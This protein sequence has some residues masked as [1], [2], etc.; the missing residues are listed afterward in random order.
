MVRARRDVGE[1]NISAGGD[2]IVVDGRPTTRRAL[3][4]AAQTLNV[5]DRKVIK[6]LKSQRQDWQDEAWDCY[7]TTPL[8]G[9]SSDFTA[10]ALSRLRF[11]IAWQANVSDDPSEVNIDSPPEEMP[12]DAYVKAQAILARL[13]HGQGLMEMARKAAYGLTIPG[14]LYVLGRDEEDPASGDITERFDAYSTSEL[15]LSKADQGKIA[16]QTEP[17][18]DGE[19]IE[20]DVETAVFFRVW[21]PHP[22][23][24]QI[25][26]TPMRR[27]LEQCEEQALLRRYMRSASRSR[28]NMGLLEVPEEWELGPVHNKREGETFGYDRMGDE[29]VTAFS[30]GIADEAS[31]QNVVPY[32]VHAKAA[33][34]GKARLI[35]FGRDFDQL[36]LEM[37]R[38]LD[39]EIAS[40]IDLPD[41]V[42][43][44]LGDVKF[45][46]AEV[47]TQEQ[48]KLHL[49][50][51]AIVWVR[52]LT[53]GF[54]TVMLEDEGVAP[55]I[56]RQFTIWYDSAAVTSQTDQTASSN[57]GYDRELISGRT[58]RQVNNYTEEDA[59]DEEERE[60]RKA[61]APEA[62]P[63]VPPQQGF[64]P[65]P[66]DDEGGDTAKPNPFAPKDAGA[67]IVASGRRQR[68]AVQQLGRRLAV[69]ELATRLKVQTA[70]DQAMRRAFER[71]GSASR[72]RAGKVASATLLKGV[73]NR[74]IV[75]TI[76]LEAVV[77][78][79]VNPAAHL[80]AEL[81]RLHD[82][83]VE[84]VQ[85]HQF[86]VVEMIAKATRRPAGPLIERSAASWAAGV[87]NAWAEMYGR[88]HKL[89]GDEF[90][91]SM[92]AA[93][94]RKRPVTPAAPEGE[95]AEFL[96]EF[97]VTMS[98]PAGLV[99][100]MLSIAGGVT[101]P[102]EDD[103]ETMGGIIGGPVMD[104][105]FDA[106]GL[107]D[108][109]SD[110]G[111]F[112]W[113][114]GDSSTRIRPFEPHERLNGE[115]FTDYADPIL[116]NDEA[117]PDG[118]YYFPG[119]HAYC[120]CEVAPRLVETI[121][122]VVDPVAPSTLRA[123]GLE[124]APAAEAEAAKLGHPSYPGNPPI[125]VFVGQEE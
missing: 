2:T 74:D 27:V 93:A 21:R 35:T 49:E 108:D 82:T 92:V 71:I 61:A 89:A 114:Y 111:G 97:D 84:I 85:A 39:E 112:E 10:N 19:R 50:P 31:A 53:V 20:I 9:F 77:R 36:A 118:P 28:L 113:L 123:R 42:L 65:A 124:K 11:L 23:F 24:S 76:G 67:A 104:D 87:E 15:D 102:Q 101:V 57:F 73:E 17:G 115:F 26:S 44:G 22:R 122:A 12:L 55:E 121:P 117:F 96:G 56:A 7:D 70:A 95:A 34:L 60:Q 103:P 94:P 14:E 69:T 1:T 107:S 64:S 78:L 110:G 33:T 8:V 6:R 52:A 38:R 75:A 45:R 5:A 66:G 32:I 46:N 30:T 62:L 68:P 58:W 109:P 116:T 99:R 16:I 106:V 80:D 29:L 4:A 79:G 47:I 86:R 3:T 63:V 91:L 119:D 90:F 51:L 88:L 59:P 48:F 40:G 98:V 105:L 81:A 41:Q 125:P 100:E 54:L 25:A 18:S 43:L 72:Q 120:Q 13:D 37:R 83:F